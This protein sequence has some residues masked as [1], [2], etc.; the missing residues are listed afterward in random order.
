TSTAQGSVTPSATGSTTSVADA[1][2]V[3]PRI[4]TVGRESRW[5][6]CPWSSGRSAGRSTDPQGNRAGGRRVS[7]SDGSTGRG[8]RRWQRITRRGVGEL[9]EH[10]RAVGGERERHRG[11]AT[12][13]G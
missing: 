13:D 2:W 5:S 3:Y 7:R 12:A 10:G 8:P 9:G 6:T 4:T 11:E 1:G